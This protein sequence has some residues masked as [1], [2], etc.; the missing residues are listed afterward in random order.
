MD[1]EKRVDFVCTTLSS[2]TYPSSGS[3]LESPHLPSTVSTS[4]HTDW[5]FH[6]DFPPGT[7]YDS[8]ESQIINLALKLERAHLSEMLA[9]TNQPT[10]CLNPK[11]HHHDHHCCENFKSHFSDLLST[12][13]YHRTWLPITKNLDVQVEMGSHLTAE[14]IILSKKG[15]L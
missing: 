14:Y 7:L 2:P 6:L 5:S 15:I 1:P 11:E 13:V 8:F 4:L 3:C 9:S 10:W 12:G